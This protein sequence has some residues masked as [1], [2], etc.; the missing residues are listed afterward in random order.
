MVAG[1]LALLTLNG[2]VF[3]NAIVFLV[4]FSLSLIIWLLRKPGVLWG[5]MVSFHVLAM[6]FVAANLRANL[7]WQANFNAEKFHRG[8]RE[9]PLAGKK[10]G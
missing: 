10:G 9:V 8:N 2:Q 7:D 6:A 1:T 3:T 5:L 4:C